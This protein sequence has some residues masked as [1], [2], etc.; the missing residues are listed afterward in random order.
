[1]IL[2]GQQGDFQVAPGLPQTNTPISERKEGTSVRGNKEDAEKQ[3]ENSWGAQ[4]VPD[5]MV[6]SEAAGP[7]KRLDACGQVDPSALNWNH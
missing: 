1:M 3:G 2:S 7:D 4:T 5:Y 6:R